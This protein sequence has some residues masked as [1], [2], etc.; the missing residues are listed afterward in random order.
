MAFAV[1]EITIPNRRGAEKSVT[2]DELIKG[3]LGK[4][5]GRVEAAPIHLESLEGV[6][7]AYRETLEE[8]FDSFFKSRRKN[9]V[10][11]KGLG[12]IFKIDPIEKSN[13]VED[14][15]FTLPVQPPVEDPEFR[16]PVQPPGYEVPGSGFV[17]PIEPPPQ[18]SN[19]FYN[20]MALTMLATKMEWLFARLNFVNGMNKTILNYVKKRANDLNR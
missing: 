17:L 16:L 19:P 15:V 11:D 7:D 12:P 20:L 8:L 2:S 1:N 9:P 3:L 4:G 5:S 10:D 6:L 14:P 18:S 13:P